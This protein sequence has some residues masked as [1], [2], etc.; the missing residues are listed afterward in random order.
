MII[1]FKRW[2]Q[3]T[4]FTELLIM[5]LID[6]D[7]LSK[8][9]SSAF[10][11]YTLVKMYQFHSIEWGL[12]LNTCQTQKYMVVFSCYF[13]TTLSSEILRRWRSNIKPIIRRIGLALLHTPVVKMS[14]FSQSTLLT[15][16]YNGCLQFN[17]SFKQKNN[18]D[19]MDLFCFLYMINFCKMYDVK[20]Q[21]VADTYDPPVD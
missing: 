6:L 17:V 13:S 3:C 2:N 19:F 4:L 20:I 12:I 8:D 21:N 1:S 9:K 16:M 15:T 18:D 5:V 14:N 7:T 10:C 11:F